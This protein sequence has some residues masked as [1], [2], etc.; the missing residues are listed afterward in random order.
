MFPKEEP[1]LDN[2]ELKSSFVGK[3]SKVHDWAV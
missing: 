1:S 3:K 2:N